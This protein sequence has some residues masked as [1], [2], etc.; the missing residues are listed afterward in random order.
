MKENNFILLFYENNGLILLDLEFWLNFADYRNPLQLT[1][2]SGTK[3]YRKSI[4]VPSHSTGVDH[5][6]I[7]SL[8]PSK[9]TR[10]FRQ[11]LS[12]LRLYLYFFWILLV[13]LILLQLLG[14]VLRI[15]WT[16]ALPK[17]SKLSVKECVEALML[18]RMT[19]YLQICIK[20]IEKLKFNKMWLLRCEIFN[21]L[22]ITCPHAVHD[23]HQFS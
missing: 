1:L 22:L 6:H 20:I 10:T 8:V 19:F 5:S 23:F 18:C 11:R 15:L 9:M 12:L 2:I 16:E 3:W 13:H 4:L 17:P 21:A 14:L 7:C